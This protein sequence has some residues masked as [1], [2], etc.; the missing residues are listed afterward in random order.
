[1]P[2]ELQVY[3]QAAASY[4]EQSGADGLGVDT[5]AGIWVSSDDAGVVAEV[6][7]LASA[8]FPNVATENIVTITFDTPVPGGGEL[9][10]HSKQMVRVL[11]CDVAPTVETKT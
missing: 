6:R 7:Q 11:A 2:G 5:I 3:L 4:I 8:Y 1:M 9:P 10:T